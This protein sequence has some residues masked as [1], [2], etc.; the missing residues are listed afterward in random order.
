MKYLKLLAKTKKE[1]EDL[2]KRYEEFVGRDDTFYVLKP[3]FVGEKNSKLVFAKS[4]MTMACPEVK[5]YVVADD[6]SIKSVNYTSNNQEV[7][8]QDPWAETR[9]F[10]KSWFAFM[11][12]ELNAIS[13]YLMKEYIREFKGVVRKVREEQKGKIEEVYDA[14]T[15]RFILDACDRAQ[16]AIN[17]PKEDPRLTQEY[18]KECVDLSKKLHIEDLTK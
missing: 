16:G 8:K 15:E 13:P 5:R 6:F 17:K 9:P 14:E 10:S 7:K 4:Y 12:K 11:C 2:Y 1:R 3:I 18:L